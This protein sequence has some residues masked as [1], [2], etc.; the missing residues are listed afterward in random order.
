MSF[1]SSTPPGSLP[2]PLG[3]CLGC[4][5]FCSRP[6]LV[7]LLARPTFSYVRC[8]WWPW[9]RV[10]GFPSWVPSYGPRSLP[11]LLLVWPR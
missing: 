8:F 5:I 2:H 3:P 7:L 11:S 4:W 1:F 6:G 10:F 9:L